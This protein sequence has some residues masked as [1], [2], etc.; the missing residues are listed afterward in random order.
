[1]RTNKLWKMASWLLATTMVVTM[2]LVGV[3]QTEKSQEQVTIK[4]VPTMVVLYTIYRG[5]YAQIGPSI[6]KLYALAGQKGIQPRGGVTCAYLNN[7]QLESKE[8]WL[9][10]IRI[11]VAKEALKRTGS[12][13]EFTDIKQLP[14][15]EVAVIIKPE[16]MADPAPLF[17]KLARSIYDNGYLNVAGPMETYLTN[18]MSGNYASMKAEIAIPVGKV[19]PKSKK[20]KEMPES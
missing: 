7:P 20:A 6:G 14:A 1:M 15:M 17:E 18:A 5:D 3:A 4:K 2:A 11:P 10:E 9:T 12:L 13:G 8:H 16:G 19:K